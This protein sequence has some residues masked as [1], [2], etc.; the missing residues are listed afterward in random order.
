MIRCHDF[1][2]GEYYEDTFTGEKISLWEYDKRKY[3]EEKRRKN[4]QYIL[5]EKCESLI[6]DSYFYCDMFRWYYNPLE[7]K[8]KNVIVLSETEYIKKEE[9][10]YYY[11][12]YR[13]KSYIFLE[14]ITNKKLKLEKS[15]KLEKQKNSL[16]EIK[17]GRIIIYRSQKQFLEENLI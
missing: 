3:E 12:A 17:K 14:V 10:G 9:D 7:E 16:V 8:P 6:K 13:G 15:V 1:F 4:Q 5:I 11:R 2:N